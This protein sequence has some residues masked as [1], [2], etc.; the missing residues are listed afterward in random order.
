M[1]QVRI[2]I[3]A[4]LSSQRLPG[5][6]LL[7]I[8][9]YPIAALCALRAA[10]NGADVVVATS[11]DVSDDALVDELERHGIQVFRGPLHD[12]LGRYEAAT[13]DLS[14]DAEVVRLTADN[15]LPDGMMIDKVLDLFR[16]HGVKYLGTREGHDGLPCGLRAEVFKV[17]LIRKAASAAT[18]DFQREHV[19]PWMIER[20]AC[21]HYLKHTD[22]GLPDLADVRCTID[23]FKDYI[24]VHR[25]FKGVKDPV[26]VHFKDLIS[27][28]RSE[29]S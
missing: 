15:V 18:S 27:R 7:S 17:E 9:G 6:S 13:K 29:S 10:N 5:K 1:G 25:L 8:C 28:C 3:Q 21:E 4:R 12:V 24:N 14:D 2:I 22:L 19:T 16:E 26:A 20:Y 11:T 23:T